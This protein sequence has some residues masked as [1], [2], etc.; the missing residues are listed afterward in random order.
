[1]DKWEEG[2]LEETD[3]LVKNGKISAIGKNISDASA[4]SDAKESI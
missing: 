4:T 2:I 1:M 3:V